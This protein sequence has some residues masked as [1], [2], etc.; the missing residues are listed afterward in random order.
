[1][2]HGVWSGHHLVR[3][4]QRPRRDQMRDRA[5]GV[6]SARRGRLRHTRPTPGRRRTM[7][8]ALTAVRPQ[9][10]VEAPTAA[11]HLPMIAAV[12]TDAPHLVTVVDL[13]EDRL[14]PTVAKGHLRTAVA[15]PA[16]AE[17]HRTVVEAD[18]PADTAVDT[19]QRQATARVAVALAAHIAMAVTVVTTN[20]TFKMPWR[21]TPPSGGVFSCGVRLMGFIPRWR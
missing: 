5:H 6:K 16:A 12:R 7:A 14:R 9:A 13:P 19:P 10:T 15:D 17:L 1:V 11:P 20:L 3:A 18:R 4:K 2:R 8:E 21:D